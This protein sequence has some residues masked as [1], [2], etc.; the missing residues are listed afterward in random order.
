MIESNIYDSILEDDSNKMRR[1]LEDYGKDF[2][3]PLTV[4]RLKQAFFKKF[5]TLPPLSMDIEQSDRLRESERINAI[6]L[7]NMIA[8]YSL[9]EIWNP[10]E[11]DEKH[12]ISERIYL[13]G[14][15]KAV[16]SIIRD[17]ISTSLELY[18]ENERKEILL[19]E[20]S[21][22]DW[23]L[24]EKSISLIMSHRIWQDPSQDNLN[25]LRMN[26]ET[27]V[28]K[29]LARRGLSINWILNNSYDTGNNFID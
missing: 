20:I 21:E 24:I 13:N 22:N 19:R 26:N 15:F 11:N 23:E 28:R 14:S 7:L 8:D 18:D 1:Y 9:E 25:S 6:R 2:K 16:C 5:I 29:Y 27:L 4:N 17:A 10:S 12:G 3:K